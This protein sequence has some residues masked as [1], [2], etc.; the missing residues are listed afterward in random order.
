[1]FCQKKTNFQ[2][3]VKMTL[4]SLQSLWASDSN[5]VLSLAKIANQQNTSY[6][7]WE[8]KPELQ[9]FYFY[10]EAHDNS[11]QGSFL[12]RDWPQ[13]HSSVAKL[14]YMLSDPDPLLAV[15]IK[16]KIIITNSKRIFSVLKDSPNDCDDIRIVYIAGYITKIAAHTLSIGC[17]AQ[18]DTNHHYLFRQLNDDSSYR[19]YTMLSTTLQPKPTLRS[20]VGKDLMQALAPN[21]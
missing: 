11:H 15:N 10:S 1:V 5:G 2:L 3:Q 16:D 12:L 8:F 19:E 20:L 13:K 4:P 18:S 14:F 9:K 7:Q 6:C 21:Y 17:F